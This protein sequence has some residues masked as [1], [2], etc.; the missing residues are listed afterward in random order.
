MNVSIGDIYSYQIVYYLIHE[1]HYQIVKVKQHKDDIWLMSADQQAYPVIRIVNATND[2]VVSQTNYI[3]NVHRSL[4]DMIHR[5]GIV[6]IINT[7]PDSEAMDTPFMK[8]VQ[9]TTKG[10]SHTDILKTFKNLHH[11]IEDVQDVDAEFAQLTKRIEEAQ[12]DNTKQFIKKAKRHMKPMVTFTIIGLCLFV[13]FMV[14]GLS[15]I[16]PNAA[17]AYITGGAYYKM[18]I[19]AAHE[20]WRL[21]TA[22]FL[23]LDPVTLLFQVFTVYSIGSSCEMYYSKWKFCLVVLASIIVGN[24]FMMVADGNVVAAGIGAGAC[25][26]Y[27]MYIM[28]IS[29]GITRSTPR[30]KKDIVCGAVY[31]VIAAFLPGISIM[32][33]IGGLLTGVVLAL[34]LTR[35]S[36]LAILRR[37]AMIAGSLLMVSLL[38]WIGFH[39]DV[40]P[41]NKDLDIQ[42]I[43]VYH[44]TPLAKYGTYLETSFI[45]QYE[46]QEME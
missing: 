45:S 31:L 14:Y 34:V 35:Y 40:E 32:A 38:V 18:N 6:L 42:L 24:M 4:L 10:V 7:S 44:D 12:N 39:Q 28:A 46:I 15:F 43:K 27:G 29:Q 5:E 2:E 26:M 21:L 23:Q 16:M 41:I 30:V 17:I 9:V 25:G 3:R 36:K 33:H 37:H 11:V 13:S 8:Q 19:I 1:Y 22:G 20:Y